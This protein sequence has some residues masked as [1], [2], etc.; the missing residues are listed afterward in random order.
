MA[1]GTACEM[2]KAADLIKAA[3]SK[4]LAVRPGNS[5]YCLAKQMTPWLL[6]AMPRKTGSMMK[7]Q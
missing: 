4:E 1:Q 2:A 5:K 6:A 7:T 3:G